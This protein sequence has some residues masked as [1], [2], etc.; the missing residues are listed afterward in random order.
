MTRVINRRNFIGI[1]AATGAG[2]MISKAIPAQS[3]NS[4]DELNVAL[5]GAGTQGETLMTTCLK[6][7]K[8]SGIRFKAADN[9]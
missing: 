7:G 4:N 1:T 5:I 2:L 3:K 6:M 9:P 8:D